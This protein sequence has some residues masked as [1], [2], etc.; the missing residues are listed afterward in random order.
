MTAARQ[1]YLDSN[2]FIGEFISEFCECGANYAAP[3]KAF[4]EKLKSEYPRDCAGMN[5]RRLVETIIKV[6]ELFAD[7]SIIGNVPFLSFIFLSFQISI[8]L[9]LKKMTSS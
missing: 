9:S 5:D 1:N 6:E 2:D 7:I 8:I 4:I 3:R